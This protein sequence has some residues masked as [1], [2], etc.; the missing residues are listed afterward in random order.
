MTNT[1]AKNIATIKACISEA[2]LSLDRKDYEMVRESLK[3]MA[4]I[5]HD[6]ETEERKEDERQRNS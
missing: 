5:I 4:E 1:K 6:M 3:I 2:K